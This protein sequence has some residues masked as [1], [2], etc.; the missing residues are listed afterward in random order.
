MFWHAYM[1]AYPDHMCVRQDSTKERK[2]EINEI[3]E[4][5]VVRPC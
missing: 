4:I 3:K 5:F 1:N 2:E